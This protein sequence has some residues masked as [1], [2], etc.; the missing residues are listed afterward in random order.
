MIEWLRV[1]G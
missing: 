1:S